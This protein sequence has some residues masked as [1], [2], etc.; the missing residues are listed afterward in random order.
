MRQSALPPESHNSQLSYTFSEEEDAANS[1]ADSLRQVE[2]A[3]PTP[4]LSGM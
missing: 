3:E 4:G 1:E 2:K